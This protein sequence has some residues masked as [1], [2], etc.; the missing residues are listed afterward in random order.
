M[1]HGLAATWAEDYIDTHL[2]TNDWGTWAAFEVALRATFTDKVSKKKAREEV[3]HYEQKGKRIDEYITVLSSLFKSAEMTDDT[4]RIRLLE[5]GTH[6][7]TIGAIYNSRVVPTTYNAY[8]E[9][10]LAIGRLQE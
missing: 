10:V 2:P 3:E 1:K 6:R 9:Q 5:K 8:Q 4:E 7:S